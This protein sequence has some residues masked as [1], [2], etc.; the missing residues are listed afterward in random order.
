MHT[1]THTYT[2]RHTYT[3]THTYIYTHT[4]HIDFRNQEPNKDDC[5]LHNYTVNGE[6]FAAL[7]F[8]FF[9]V[10]QEFFYEYKHLSLIILNNICISGKGNMKVFPQKLQWG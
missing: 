7:D 9:I 2:H 4:L 1:H 3:H 10:P 6:R 8:A 5:Q